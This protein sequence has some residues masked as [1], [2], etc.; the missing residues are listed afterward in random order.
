MVVS[1]LWRVVARARGAV[2]R[3]VGLG[4][5]EADERAMQEEMRFHLDRLAQRHVERGSAP[6]EARR[7]AA[8]EFGSLAGHQ[9]AA[10]E[11][12]HAGFIDRLAQDLRY[13]ARML[14][15]TPVLTA[16]AVA[17]LS[18]GIGATS[19][20]F[21]LLDR[22]LLRT[23]P[24]RHPG[25]L[26]AVVR[27][28]SSGLSESIP[29]PLFRALASETVGVGS[30]AGYAF[31]VVAVPDAADSVVVQLTSAAWFETVAVRPQVGRT[32]MPA[33][34]QTADQVAVISDG[35][36]RRRFG[37]SAAALGSTLVL[38]GKPF[39]VIGVMAR[40]FRGVSLDYPADVWLPM[41][42][43][44][45]LDGAS[46]LDDANL[47]WVRTIVRLAPP[48]RASAVE[49]TAN[50]ALAR[51]R[52]AGLSAADT[53]ERLTLVS[54]SRPD[55]HDRSRVARTLYL[56]TALAA[57]VLLIACVN[58]AHLQ[59]ARA[60]TR[61]R[62]M[63][64]RLALGA[65]RRRLVRQLM[66]ES[67]LLAGCSGVVGLV[68]ALGIGRLVAVFAGGTLGGEVAPDFQ[69]LVT[70][71]VLAFTVLLALLVAVAFGLAP[72]LRSTRVDVVGALKQAAL[73]RR[74]AGGPG[75]RNG[76]LVAQLGVSIVLLV[77]AGMIGRTLLAAESLNLGFD[78]RG[79]VQLSVDW[80]NASEPQSRATVEAIAAA[81]RATPGV[82]GA[83]VSVPAAFGRP[84]VSTSAFHVAGDPSP[85]PRSIE[86]MSVSPEF[87]TVMRIRVLR[88]RA[89]LST[90]GEGAP[91]VVVLNESAARLFLP[92]QD[93]VG[94]RFELMGRGRVVRV[95]GL[96]GD[97]RLHSVVA[98]PPPLAYIPFAQDLGGPSPG[99]PTLEVRTAPDA[100]RL[101]E[102]TRVVESVDRRLRVQAQP[103]G[104][105]IGESLALERLS[106]WVTGGF[107]LAGLLLA[108]LGVYGLHSYFV[109]RRTP[110]LGLR[111]ALGASA[112]Q[113]RWLVWRQGMR[114]VLG[115][116]ALGLVLA[117]AS[118]R[119]IRGKVFGLASV[120]P[121]VAAATTLLLIAVA[122]IA[123]Y[124]PARRASK[125]NPAVTLRAE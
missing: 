69:G 86:V 121:R 63:A 101:Q 77:G 18:L 48:R 20:L 52:T 39:V 9:E 49:A 120:D 33:E 60:A 1:A 41:E 106:A 36:W 83:S 43:E 115:G 13:G 73:M 42:L 90:D 123:C 50:L 40:G 51:R 92:G 25:Q 117:V 58:I 122:G 124:L 118:A 119:L 104:E 87:F 56:V 22:L 76:L 27:T 95:V 3:L 84:T 70:T 112:G 109:T 32:W 10:R 114:P 30:V 12:L 88:G 108:V 66:T 111:L 4:R 28:R 96:V 46:Q 72:A 105:V 23:L 98:D 93:P 94:G 37:R 107:G 102:L 34:A 82:V 19:S 75:A 8:M 35:L 53:T 113:V 59:L 91:N 2:M 125:L 81:L 67:V 44:P 15:R 24:V 5:R 17:T 85:E 55:A 79:L 45:Q 21:S 80:R 74:G 11:E 110:E 78:E 54:A 89:F 29:Y 62:E 16:A 31:R 68:L 57:L 14:A 103:L 97:A 71:H 47:N 61:R 65:S 7:Q 100:P 116:A 6:E 64:V 26:Y 38:E 99:L